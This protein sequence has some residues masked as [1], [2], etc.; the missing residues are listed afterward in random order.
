MH[1]DLGCIRGCLYALLFS[2]LTVLGLLVCIWHNIT[3]LT[4]FT[5]HKVQGHKWNACH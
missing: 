1:I 3:H 2:M 4:Q 5:F